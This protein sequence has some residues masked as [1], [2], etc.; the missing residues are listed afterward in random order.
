MGLAIGHVTHR[1]ERGEFRWCEHERPPCGEEFGWPTEVFRGGGVTLRDGVRPAGC[2]FAIQLEVGVAL[3]GSA[4][5]DE[6][7]LMQSVEGAVEGLSLVASV[8]A[9][10]AQRTLNSLA[11]STNALKPHWP[12]DMHSRDCGFS[13]VSA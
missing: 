2:T 8:Y 9:G 1:Q 5:V 12:W 11:A 13:G 10:E 4:Q 3:P 6:F 7:P